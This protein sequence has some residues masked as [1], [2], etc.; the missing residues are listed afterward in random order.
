[1]ANFDEE[2][3]IK[4]RDEFSSQVDKISKNSI[5]L[6]GIWKQLAAIGA[7]AFAVTAVKESVAAYIENEQQALQLKGSLMALGIQSEAL[8]KTYLAFAQTME[9]TTMFTEEQAISAQRLLIQYRIGGD[10]MRRTIKVASD[11]ATA[12]GT[13]LQSATMAIIKAQE[14]NTTA[15]K[16]MGVSVTDAT[17]ATKGLG[18]VLDEVEK[19]FGG[20][21]KSAEQGFGAALDKFA[22]A[23]GDVAKKTGEGISALNESFGKSPFALGGDKGF[24]Q[25]WTDIFRQFT[26]SISGS[27]EGVKQLTEASEELAKAEKKIT[28]PMRTFLN[29]EAQKS[30][31]DFLADL[32]KRSGGVFDQI[33]GDEDAHLKKLQSMF[34]A[35]GLK[36]SEYLDAR[37]MLE[38]EANK[39]SMEAITSLIVE[40]GNAF[41]AGITSMKTNVLSGL[42]SMSSS[43]LSIIGKIS[44]NAGF[45]LAGG[46]I[47]TFTSVV[48][49][50]GSLFGD[51]EKDLRGYFT[52]VTDQLEVLKRGVDD[53]DRRVNEKEDAANAIA[54]GLQ[55]RE[56]T[57]GDYEAVTGLS[58]QGNVSKQQAYAYLS[59][60]ANVTPDDALAFAD[61]IKQA[62]KTRTISWK[63]SDDGIFVVSF[64]GE[65]HAFLN[66]A[67]TWETLR[68]WHSEELTIAIAHMMYDYAKR[69]GMDASAL[70]VSVEQREKIKAAAASPANASLPLTRSGAIGVSG[71]SRMT[72][73]PATGSMSGASVQNTV[74][75]LSAIDEAGVQDFL[76]SKLAPAMRRASGRQG[77]VLIS[78]KGVSSNI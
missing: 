45:G 73:N 50:I 67:G 42:S 31:N 59:P 38:K 12:M 10:E 5:S 13:D 14:G 34:T 35:A 60:Y 15:L 53:V 39:K 26:D 64:W 69:N 2:V 3:V 49:A 52:R 65:P 55:S 43:A 29:E 18:G 61:Q 6:Q 37:D 40:S 74:I 71:S 54:N 72:Y 23:I 27:T 46:I 70:G 1:M 57:Q 21:A 20:F 33:N 7:T 9:R 25:Q 62:F 4:L 63:I 28:A 56:L 41:S 78:S 24:I 48:G 11:L 36:R 51:S 58:W 8:N 77:V 16:R 75:N 68:I 32:K 17:V 19:K 22:K 30:Y 47:S 44:G 76:L 66:R